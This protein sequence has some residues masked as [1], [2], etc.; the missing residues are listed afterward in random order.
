M[1]FLL[2][3]I[4]I[5]V[6]ISFALSVIDGFSI[7]DTS[8]LTFIF[9]LLSFVFISFAWFNNTEVTYE[10]IDPKMAEIEGQQVTYYMDHKGNF[11]PVPSNVREVKVR[12]PRKGSLDLIEYKLKY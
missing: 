11:V 12:Y 6:F 9:L 4:A 8:T 5:G 10:Y 3:L 2:S 1:E 7:E